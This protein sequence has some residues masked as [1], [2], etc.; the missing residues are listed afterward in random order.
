MMY[1][2]SGLN[3]TSPY[4][5]RTLDL[6]AGFKLGEGG[7]ALVLAMSIYDNTLGYSSSNSAASATSV[8]YATNGVPFFTNGTAAATNTS[9]DSATPLGRY[10]GNRG[11]DANIGLNLKIAKDVNLGFNYLVNGVENL[12]SFQNRG[13]TAKTFTNGTS[14]VGYSQ[15]YSNTYSNVGSF[16]QQLTALFAAGT[17]EGTVYVAL[18][19]QRK[20]FDYR[21]DATN[22]DLYGTGV[23]MKREATSVSGTANQT[24]AAGMDSMANVSLRHSLFSV[25]TQLRFDKILD[26]KWYLTADWDHAIFPTGVGADTNL[27]VYSRSTVVQQWNTNLTTGAAPTNTVSTREANQYTNAAYD[28]FALGVRMYHKWKF[29]TVT[30]GVYPRALWNHAESRYSHYA[31]F[32]SNF[33]QDVNANGTLTDAG[34]T[35]FTATYTTASDSRSILSNEFEVRLPFATQWKVSPQFTFYLGATARYL[36]SVTTERLDEGS[37]ANILASTGSPLTDVA[38]YVDSSGL[39]KSWGAATTT[40]TTTVVTPRLIGSYSLGLV[41]SPSEKVEFALTFNAER[42]FMNDSAGAQAPLLAGADLSFAYTF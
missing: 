21:L 38:S 42:P 20:K 1:K 14:L 7:H 24:T 23:A 29:D 22:E 34:D 11:I 32:Q 18:A 19:D 35:N 26:S 28:R 27:N 16:R 8:E 4:F 17:F 37:V 15:G 36:V 33:Q 10:Y 13:A 41:W 25:G 5:L 31:T 9:Q 39:A 40:T 3:T 2:L 12:N 30:L 6:G